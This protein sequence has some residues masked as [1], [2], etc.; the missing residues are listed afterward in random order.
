MTTRTQT[1]FICA[2]LSMVI[3]TISNGSAW[4]H[5]NLEANFQE[6]I[7]VADF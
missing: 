3:V 6:Y 5:N 4:M 7:K 1:L 2:M